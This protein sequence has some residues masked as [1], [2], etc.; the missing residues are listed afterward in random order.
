[1]TDVRYFYH[2]QAY[3]DISDPQ[4]VR[5]LDGH[6]TQ[7]NHLLQDV[8]YPSHP[9]PFSCPSLLRASNSAAH[10]LTSIGFPARGFGC[11]HQLLQ[12]DIAHASLPQ[13]SP[14][15]R[16]NNNSVISIIPPE[17]FSGGPFQ[18]NV[19]HPGHSPPIP[20][21]PKASNSNAHFS[22]LLVTSPQLL[23]SHQHQPPLRQDGA[24][25]VLHSSSFLSRAGNNGLHSIASSGETWD[26]P[27]SVHCPN[28]SGPSRPEV[29]LQPVVERKR[30]DAIGVRN[31]R[32]LC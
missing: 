25:M 11:Q 10:S 12:Q 8:I 28:S 5:L 20:N 23:T 29:S 13:C 14:F 2:T 3:D 19:V 1:M 24:H 16:V 27:I 22:A 15:P 9:F 17:T 32:I 26:L 31:C 4:P 7:D 21:S 6:A 18:Q 30:A